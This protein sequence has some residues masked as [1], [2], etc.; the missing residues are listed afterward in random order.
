MLFASKRQAKV[1]FAPCPQL[2]TNRDE[3]KEMQ[4]RANHV[5]RWEKRLHP[6]VFHS[7]KAFILN[8]T[9][10]SHLVEHGSNELDGRCVSV[11]VSRTISAW[12]SAPF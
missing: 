7:H 4:G 11:F 6:G 5:C 10:T 2:G 8:M 1:R 12:A 9:L 3:G